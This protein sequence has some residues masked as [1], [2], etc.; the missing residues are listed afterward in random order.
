M[1]K[2]TESATMLIKFQVVDDQ[3]T[4][5]DPYLLELNPA[6]T[7]HETRGELEPKF[8]NHRQNF[9]FLWKERRI[10]INRE[11]SL[12]L[13][14]IL[15]KLNRGIPVESFKFKDVQ[16]QK[17]EYFKKGD[18]FEVT[19]CG[20]VFLWKESGGIRY[21]DKE[22][23]SILNGP[24]LY[25]FSFI[26]STILTTDPVHDH[27]DEMCEIAAEGQDLQ[28]L[29]S[30]LVSCLP[31]MKGDFVDHGKNTP[32]HYAATNGHTDVCRLL[33]N[34]LGSNVL[35]CKDQNGRTPLHCAFIRQRMDVIIYML[36][37]KPD[38]DAKDV[39]GVSCRKL[40]FKL[41]QSKIDY[42]FENIDFNIL[43]DRIILFLTC[44]ALQ[45][46]NISAGRKLCKIVKPISSSYFKQPLNLAA[47]FGNVELT[48]M[49]LNREDSDL[50]SHSPLE[51]D[52]NG[53]LPLHYACQH[54]H[55]DIIPL[56]YSDVLTE[57]DFQR[58]TKLMVSWR[59]FDALLCLSELRSNLVIDQDLQNFLIDE[60][61]RDL[62]K[63]G[64]LIAPVLRSTLHA[65]QRI[66]SEAARQN[67][68][69]VI[70]HLYSL[71]MRLDLQDEM[72]RTPLHEACQLGHG[73][74]ISYLI[75]HGIDCHLQDWQGSTALHYACQTGI[76]DSVSLLLDN[77]KTSFLIDI[78]DKSGRN[79]LLTAAYCGH[80]DVVVYL[81]KY[82]SC[83]VWMVD[84]YNKSLLNYL[85]LLNT[86]SVP[87]IVEILRNCKFEDKT[88]EKLMVGKPKNRRPKMATYQCSLC[89]KIWHVFN[90]HES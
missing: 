85:L 67:N 49:L 60:A 65:N 89:Q 37:F 82:T 56:L 59:K 5:E 11:K 54:G 73:E 90:W 66:A 34:H 88:S 50:P 72:G 20:I 76:L 18:K 1:A 42:L 38:L 83:D 43:D 74:M 47:E 26:P 53:H 70:E 81:L 51:Y 10:K 32:L 4:Q 28:T 52:R 63:N 41:P 9:Q 75:D 13:I 55:C 19:C 77:P 48:K 57:K 40:M 24:H 16:Y 30:L 31:N 78:T 25:G 2:D 33:V 68:M 12:K 14:D 8:P 35:Q 15:P 44:L 87:V 86:T 79:P 29:Q 45:R 6:L 36:S 21:D 23:R 46:K 39:L 84:I 80:T 27:I 71:G 17:M 61:E 22:M 7:L 3:K 69:D 58:A 64:K 62:S